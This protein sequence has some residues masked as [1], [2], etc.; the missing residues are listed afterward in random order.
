MLSVRDGSISPVCWLIGNRTVHLK[1]WRRAKIF[2]S[3]G[4]DSSDRYS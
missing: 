2:A 1:P 3:A 4:M